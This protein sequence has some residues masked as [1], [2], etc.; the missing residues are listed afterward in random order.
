LQ[1]NAQVPVDEEMMAED[2]TP[3]YEGD[4]YGIQRY[5]TSYV[6]DTP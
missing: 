4:V 1:E 2:V 6:S 5:N 3:L